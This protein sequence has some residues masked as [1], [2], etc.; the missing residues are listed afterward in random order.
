MNDK[1]AVLSDEKLV[2][3]ADGELSEQEAV[4]IEQALSQDPTAGHRLR[5][6][7]EAGEMARLAFAEIA[8]EPVPERL[9]AAVMNAPTASDSEASTE[10][11][12]DTGDTSREDTPNNVVRLPRRQPRQQAVWRPVALAASLAFA[13]AAGVFAWLSGGENSGSEGRLTAQLA[14]ALSQ[15]PSY[16]PVQLADGEVTVIGSFLS[17]DDRFCREFEQLSEAG[18]ERGLVCR[19]GPDEEWQLVASSTI[20]SADTSGTEGF[21]PAGADSDDPVAA[22]VDR[23]QAGSLLSTEEERRALGL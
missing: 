11:T 7:V 3:Y 10:D 17:Q 21:R 1:A 23:L 6:L 20:A 16:E 22:A 8:E 19:T 18:G 5:A 12:Q 14:E 4:E 13:V 9:R 15:T 2:A